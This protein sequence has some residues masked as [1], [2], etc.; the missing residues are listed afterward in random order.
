MNIPFLG[1]LAALAF[2]EMPQL[3]VRVYVRVCL[4]LFLLWGLLLLMGAPLFDTLYLRT[5]RELTKYTNPLVVQIGMDN[6]KTATL[7]A[8]LV[9]L[10]WKED[11]AVNTDMLRVESFVHFAVTGVVFVNLIQGF[12]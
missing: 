10:S 7:F 5:D 4:A 11:S 3:N 8:C 1:V 6:I 9:A 12:W 2:I